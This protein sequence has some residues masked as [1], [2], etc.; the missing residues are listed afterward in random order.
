MPPP[1]RLLPFC[2]LEDKQSVWSN[3]LGQK[4][5]IV[6]RKTFDFE[7]INRRQETFRMVKAKANRTLDGN[8][9]GP[10]I[11]SISRVH[12]SARCPR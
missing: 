12:H 3:E 2:K 6:S 9:N 7:P 11:P 8:A 4:I 1:V 5:Q 10:V